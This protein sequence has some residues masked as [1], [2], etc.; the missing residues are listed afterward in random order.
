MPTINC[1][2]HYADNFTIA[3]QFDDPEILFAIWNKD[4]FNAAPANIYFT[5][6]AW[7][8]WGFHHPTENF[9]EEFEPGDTAR[10]YATLIAVG[11]SVPRPTFPL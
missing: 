3:T 4:Q 8:G 10:R 6:R 11:D 2:T 9:A 7:N 5:P 1:L